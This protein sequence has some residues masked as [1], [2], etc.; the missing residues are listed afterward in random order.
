MSFL[1]EICGCD[2]DNECFYMLFI[3]GYLGIDVIIFEY[4]LVKKLLD[5]IVIF[6]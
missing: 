2:K 3:V 6:I 1:I 5:E 4:V